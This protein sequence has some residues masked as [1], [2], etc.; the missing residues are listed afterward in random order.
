MLCPKAVG[1]LAGSLLPEPPAPTYCAK[2]VQANAP[3]PVRGRYSGRFSA[4]RGLCCLLVSVPYLT[5]DTNAAY[6]SLRRKK[7]HSL[8]GDSA[9]TP[10]EESEQLCR[11]VPN[12]LVGLE[13]SQ[14][15]ESKHDLVICLTPQLQRRSKTLGVR[16]FR[17]VER[18]NGQ[19]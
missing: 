17:R 11:A 6:S 18:Y 8:S 14:A 5:R 4:N 3:F 15:L 9:V 16:E 2:K 1:R 10:S 7:R 19:S 12:F 13:P